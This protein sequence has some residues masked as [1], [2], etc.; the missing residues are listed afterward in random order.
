QLLPST[1]RDALFRRL[2]LSRSPRLV[3]DRAAFDDRIRPFAQGRDMDVD[4][5]IPPVDIV[6]VVAEGGALFFGQRG[7]MRLDVSRLADVFVVEY[8][9]L[10]KLDDLCDAVQVAL[11]ADERRAHHRQWREDAQQRLNYLFL[12]RRREFLV[13]LLRDGDRVEVGEQPLVE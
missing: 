10:V 1:C 3:F 2:Y 4:P 6:R 8:E 7:C 9:R 5:V 11:S 12:R 13:A